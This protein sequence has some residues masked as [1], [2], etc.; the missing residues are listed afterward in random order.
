MQKINNKDNNNNI[1]WNPHFNI[2]LIKMD[3]R[4]FELMKI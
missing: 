2:T 4:R 1:M 3:Q